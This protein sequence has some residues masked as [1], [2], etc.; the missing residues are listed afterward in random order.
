MVKVRKVRLVNYC[1]YTDTTFDFSTPDGG[2]MDFAVFFGPNGIGKCLSESTYV[3]TEAGVVQIGSLFGPHQREADR[4]HEVR[5]FKIA[6]NGGEWAT[7]RRLYSAGRKA[8]S[9]VTTAYGYRLEGSA[10]L[11]TVLA[12]RDGQIRFVRL[13][14]LAPGDRVAISRKPIGDWTSGP[15]AANPEHA[16]LLGYLVSEGY[17]AGESGVR[18]SNCD[19]WVLSDFRAICRTLFGDEPRCSPVSGQCGEYC[20]LFQQHRPKLDALGL[21]RTLSGDKT[22]PESVMMGGR[23]AAVEFLRAYFEGDGGVEPSISA[24]TCASK[25]RE[26]LRVVQ[27][28]LLRMGIVASLRQK[29]AT[30]KYAG[31]RPYASWRLTMQGENVLRFAAEV[32]FLSPRKRY[33]LDRVVSALLASDR[34]P[35]RDTVPLE[36]ARPVLESLE[37]FRREA[38]LMFP[39]SSYKDTSNGLHSLQPQYLRQVK[40]GVSRSKIEA[41]VRTLN[42]AAARDGGGVAVAPIDLNEMT[43]GFWSEDY[44]FDTVEAVGRGE[45]ELFDLEVDGLHRFWSD[46]FISHNTT[47][48]DAVRMAAN[49]RVFARGADQ[50]DRHS[51]LMRKFVHDVEYVPG[52]D[53]VKKFGKKNDMLIEVTFATDE[54]DRVVQLDNFGL[55]SSELPETTMKDGYAFWADADNPGKNYTFK[56]NAENARTFLEVCEEVY[57]YECVLASPVKS[58]DIVEYTDFIIRKGDIRVHYKRMSAG[59]R[60]IATLISDLCQP[61]LTAGKDIMLIDNVEMHVYWK[62]HK[63]MVDKLRACFAG[64]QLLCTTHSSVVINHVEP[65]ARFD[66]EHYRP[67]Y[68]LFDGDG[69]VI[70]GPPMADMSEAPLA[71]SGGAEDDPF[72]G[73]LPGQGG[74]GH[75]IG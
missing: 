24:V 23:A 26:L 59:E 45:A 25:S 37:A 32:G 73:E 62:R 48:I 1:G 39:R 63:R 6:V 57:G 68:R 56:I 64:K 54:G 69:N 43:D 8:T 28:L 67:D 61:H 13:T 18:F 12:V 38:G 70:G 53:S 51:L 42:A 71:V 11:H 74:G 22:V 40:G 9:R 16:R 15:N 30:L 31:G 10:D 58:Q 17:A 41:A 75:A 20:Y 65:E 29:N 47:G 66:L 35:N 4:W 19:E 49:P 72:D 50:T 5:P 27:L 21:T 36:L 34:N 3:H 14:D 55:R 44:F 2:V 46:G 60:K 7:V 33:E 52:I